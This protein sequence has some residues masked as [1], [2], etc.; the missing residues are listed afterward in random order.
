MNIVENIIKLRREKGISQ[1]L[2]ALALNV[3]T[4]V[5]S[6]IEN[7]KRELRTSELEKI[8]N[9]LGVDVLYLITYPDKYEKCTNGISVITPKVVLQIEVEENIKADVIKLA[10]GDRVLEVRNR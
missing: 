3:D 9:V 2:I 10:F 5:V 4:S 1:E 6:N 7:K 8:A